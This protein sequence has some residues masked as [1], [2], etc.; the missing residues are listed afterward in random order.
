MTKRILNAMD[1]EYF[2]IFGHPTC[3]LIGKREPI[4]FDYEKVFQKAKDNKIFLEI[5]SQPNR[6][7]LNGLMIKSAKEY[8]NKFV[9]NT[10]SHSI[11]QLNSIYLGI[12]QARRGWLE[13]NEVINTYPLKKFEK[14]IK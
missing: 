6:L 8:G 14:E 12:G 5:N 4:D 1:N 10:D 7:D 11:D 3:R 13:K 2:K 9:I